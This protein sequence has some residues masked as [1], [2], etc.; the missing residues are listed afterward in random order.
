MYLKL[1]L[2]YICKYFYLNTILFHSILYYLYLK[3]F[4][5]LI[6]YLYLNTIDMYLI[7]VWMQF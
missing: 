2:K 5:V 4:Q 7:Q 6:L 3:F 1:Y